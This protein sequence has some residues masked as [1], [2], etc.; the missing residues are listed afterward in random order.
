MKGILLVSNNKTFSIQNSEFYM[1]GN[2]T[3]Q[4]T[5]TLVIHNSIFTA[6]PTS[7]HRESIVLEDQAKLIVTN[8][9][10]ISKEP[11][12]FASRIVVQNDA[13][14]N[15]TY[16]TFQEE[17][18]VQAHNDSTIHV[19]DLTKTNG[20]IYRDSGIGTSGTSSVI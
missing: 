18:W 13:E 15:I 3:V 11:D 6:I 16:S 19:N 14:A 9:T 20:D 4:D 17:W 12:N 7:I 5:S 1:I 8:A 10:L 2:I